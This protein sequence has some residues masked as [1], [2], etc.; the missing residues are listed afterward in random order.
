MTSKRPTLQ[1]IDFNP[2]K[3]RKARSERKRYEPGMTVERSGIYEAFHALHRVTHQV[4][5]L[6]GHPFPLCSRCKDRV[7]FKLIKAKPSLNQSN[8]PLVH[9][10]GVFLPEAA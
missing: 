7:R 9:V 5:L 8:S 4:S 6:A 2:A 10:I 1:A 3:A